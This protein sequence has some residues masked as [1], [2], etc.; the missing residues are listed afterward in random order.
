[1][2]SQP[3]TIVR[4]ARDYAA[5]VCPTGYVFEIWLKGVP[6]TA[7]E[8]APDDDPP[9]GLLSLDNGATLIAVS[10]IAAIHVREIH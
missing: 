9:E 4:A 3:T 5:D 1:M 10:Q 7:F 6:G 2:T 8:G